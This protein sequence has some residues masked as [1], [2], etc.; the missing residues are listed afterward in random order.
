MSIFEDLENLNVSEECF[1]NIVDIVEKYINE[2]EEKDIERAVDNAYDE[3]NN[4]IGKMED[5][6]KPHHPDDVDTAFNNH[7]IRGEIGAKKKDFEE[8]M[9]KFQRHYD[10]WLDYKKEQEKKKEK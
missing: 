7:E 6:I 5:K 3:H 4:E 10:K 1:D 9:K 2:L 8:R